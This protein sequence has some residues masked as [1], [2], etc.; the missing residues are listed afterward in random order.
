MHAIEI[1]YAQRQCEV[2]ASYTSILLSLF[3]LQH[4]HGAWLTSGKHLLNFANITKFGYFGEP[5]G[6]YLSVICDDKSSDQ[7][8]GRR[9]LLWLEGARML[10]FACR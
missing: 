1:I 6:P 4:G 2:P 8:F 5:K 7:D 3:S 10:S 9:A